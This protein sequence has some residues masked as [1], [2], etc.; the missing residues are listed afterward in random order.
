MLFFTLKLHSFLRK[1]KNKLG[2]LSRKRIFTHTNNPKPSTT[3][4]TPIAITGLGSIS[5]LGSSSEEQWKSYQE[6]T[7]KIAWEE[8]LEAFTARLT[9][10]G[11][12]AI[13]AIRREDKNYLRIDPSVLYALYAGRKAVDQAGWKDGDFGINV[14]SSRGATQLFEKFYETYSARNIVPTQAS[15]STTLGNISSWLA[16]DLKSSGPDISHSI[17]CSTALHA[18]LNGVAWLQ[19]GMATR[20]LVGGSEAALTPFTLAQIRAMK[21]TPTEDTGSAYPS[22]AL[23][24]FKKKNTMALGEGASMACLELGK[25]KNALAYVTAVGYATEML[26]HA[27]SISDEGICFQKSMKM[28]LG[29]LDLSEIDAIV[30]HAPGT[31]KGDT[32]EMGAVKAVFGEDVPLLTTNKWKIG[33]SFGASGLL[34]LELAVH[35]LQEQ[36]FIGVPYLKEKTQDHTLNKILVNAV[37]F[38]GN[39]VSVLIEKA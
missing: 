5:P 29:D 39:A 11:Q 38:G 17:T 7:T 16:N 2:T 13:Q 20:F 26:E 15:P 22:M 24:L 36:R 32:S 27:V 8:E 3:L 25:K 30:M 12:K 34:S 21:L 31:L 14:G 33:H 35:M 1:F 37:G 10:E 28:A 18:L 23:N 6:T 4:K 19:S 9:E